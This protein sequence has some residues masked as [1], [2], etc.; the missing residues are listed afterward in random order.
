MSYNDTRKKKV[1][2]ECVGERPTYLVQKQSCT[3]MIFVG[4]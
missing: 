3:I 1:R 2:H 4:S